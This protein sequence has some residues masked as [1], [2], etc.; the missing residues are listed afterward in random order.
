MSHEQAPHV[1]A[2]HESPRS[3]ELDK[4]AHEL[5]KLR[6]ERAERS[7]NAAERELTEARQA[8]QAE[9]ISGDEMHKP[10]A[11]ARQPD[12]IRTRS[13]KEHS[14]NTT[15][16]HVRNNLSTPERVFSRVIHNPTIE[17]SS[18][19]IGKT[20]ARPSAITGAAIATIIG[21]LS[22]YSI[23]KFAGFALS[24]SEMPILIAVGFLA[25]LLTEW[26]YKVVK[27]LLFPQKI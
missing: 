17:K 19:F 26:L 18:E 1:E 5:E 14:F 25:G 13:D 10:Q 8:T 9:S 11:E 3:S 22:I 4:H 2:S 15:M 6:H 27:T 12:P 7:Q 20:V 24:G 23:A 16:H 21:L